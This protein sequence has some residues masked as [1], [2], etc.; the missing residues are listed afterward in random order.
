MKTKLWKAILFAPAAFIALVAG[1]TDEKTVFRDRELFE[2]PPAAA[3]SF[4]GYTNPDGTDNLTVCG[5]CHVGVQSEWEET[6]HAGAWETL[7]ASG[8]SQGFCEGCHTVGELGNPTVGDVGFA[9]APEPRYHDVQCESCHGPGLSHVQNPDASQPFAGIAVGV[10]LTTGCAEC[11]QGTHHPFAEEWEQSKH[12]EVIGFAASNPTCQ[13]CHTGDGALKAWGVNAEYIEKAAAEAGDHLP[14]TCAVCHDPHGSP[15]T[16]QLRFPINT[17]AIEENLCS[18]CHNRR[19]EP[20]PG[21]SHGLHPHAPET[22][23]LEGDVGW[24]P[25]GLQVDRGQIVATHGSEANPSLCATCHVNAF[26][27]TDQE[28]GDFVFNATGHLFTAI[29]CLGPDGVPVPGDCP[30]S[31]TDRSFDG[32]TAAGCHGSETAAF[33]ALTTGTLRIQVLAEELVGLLTQVDANLDG[34]GGEIDANDPT[35]TIAEGAFFNYALAEFPD[36]PGTRVDDRLVFAGSTVHN[37]FLMEQLLISSIQAVEA[38]YGVTPSASLVL[39]PVL[40]GN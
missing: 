40:P 23:L 1:C 14:I 21:S 18:R 25:P 20:D 22:G 12:A 13:G 17:P 11:H 10:D 19:S 27:V 16:A 32:C 37:P 9:G 5:N 6:A 4:L 38:E 34:A 26:T 8:G 35:F 39:T 29:P 36:E 3:A 33:S 30:L 24:F 7:Q 2:D 15:N 28:T 31:T